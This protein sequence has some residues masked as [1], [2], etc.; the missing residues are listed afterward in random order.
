[1]SLQFTQKRSVTNEHLVKTPKSGRKFG[2]RGGSKR[3]VNER[4]NNKL[5]L[6]LYRIKANPRDSGIK[7]ENQRGADAAKKDLPY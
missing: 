6:K 4:Q 5:L 1:M 2:Q 7:D 3:I